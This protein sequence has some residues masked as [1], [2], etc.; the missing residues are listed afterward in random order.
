MDKFEIF[1]R[2]ILRTKSFKSLIL[3]ILIISCISLQINN[4][5]YNDNAEKVTNYITESNEALFNNLKTFV[6]VQTVIENEG[7]EEKEEE[8]DTKIGTVNQT[9]AMCANYKIQ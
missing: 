6:T 9:F 1:K 7:S 5:N 2:V 3:L 4:F 8:L